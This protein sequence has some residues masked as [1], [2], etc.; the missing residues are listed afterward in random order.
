[1]WF[2]TV[3]I[4]GSNDAMAFVSKSAL[5]ARV[6][7]ML[8]RVP[9]TPTEVARIENKHVSHVS[10]ALAELKA[11]GLVESTSSY[12]RERYYHATGLGIALYYQLLRGV[13]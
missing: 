11:L 4:T 2:L 1:L 3:P 5:R 12:S 8:T 6:L 10:R 7:G 9:R 13:K